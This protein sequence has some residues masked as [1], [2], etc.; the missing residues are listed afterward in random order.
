MYP[1]SSPGYAPGKNPEKRLKTFS[2]NILTLPHEAA[3]GAPCAAGR[4]ACIRNTKLDF[5]PVLL[6]LSP[7]NCQVFSLPVVIKSVDP[8]A[9]ALS[10][11]DETGMR[12]LLPKSFGFVFSTSQFT[13]IP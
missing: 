10:K 1:T 8:Q 4:A 13:H 3:L 12:G 11:A 2:T 5:V 7:L 6:N 9:Q